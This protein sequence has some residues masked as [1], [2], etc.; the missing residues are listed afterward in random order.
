MATAAT[1]KT[2]AGPV[3]PNVMDAGKDQL[4]LGSST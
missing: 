2:G 3:F 4:S 1:K